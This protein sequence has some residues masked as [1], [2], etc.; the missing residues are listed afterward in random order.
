MNELDDWRFS[1]DVISSPNRY[2]I[3]GNKII[4]TSF[5]S[6]YER[7]PNKNEGATAYEITVYLSHEEGIYYYKRFGSQIEAKNCLNT[8]NKIMNGNLL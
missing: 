8:I 2:T 5:D 6:Y 3:N 1:K 4:S 7:Y